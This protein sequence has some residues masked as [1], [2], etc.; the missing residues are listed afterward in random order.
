M[1]RGKNDEEQAGICK[2][3]V[4]WNCQ[5]N[6]CI[7][8]CLQ[9]RDSGSPTWF[10]GKEAT[11]RLMILLKD[12]LEFSW[13]HGNVAPLWWWSDG[14]MHIQRC[15]RQSKTKIIMDVYE[16]DIE[17]ILAAQVYRPCY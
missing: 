1:I 17:K 3:S 5:D 7:N 2:F 8:C 14:N 10:N 13:E 11:D 6:V 16:L 9:I 12:P 15:I 4:H